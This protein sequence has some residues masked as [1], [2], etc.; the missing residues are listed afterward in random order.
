[1]QKYFL[2]YFLCF[3][4]VTSKT[5]FN[6]FQ[7]KIHGLNKEL[8]SNVCSKIKNFINKKDIT[9]FNFKKEIN[10]AIILGLRPLG[11]YEPSIDFFFKNIKK[12]NSNL[13]II[14]INPGKPILVKNI[15]IKLI[16]SL[17][18]DKDYQKILKF[19][20]SKIGK[21]LNHFDYE[22]LKEK[23][24]SLFM[25]KGYFD[26]QIK[27]NELRVSLKN[28][29]SYWIL[30]FDS[31]KR[32]HF[33]KVKYVG[34]QILKKYLNSIKTFKQKEYFSFKK[35]SEFNKRLIDTGWFNSVI[36]TPDINRSHQFNTNILPI[37]VF[38]SPKLQNHIEFGG[39][40]SKDIGFR[41][42]SI[43]NIP[44]V[45]SFGQSFFSMINFSN[46]KKT[47]DFIYKFPLLKSPLEQYYL[48]SFFYKNIK[49]EKKIFN[50]KILNISR[51]WNYY[52]GWQYKIG[53]KLNINFSIKKKNNIIFY[54]YI[55]FN[56]VEKEEKTIPS[57]GERHKYSINFSKKNIFSNINFITFQSKNTWIRTPIKYHRF[58]LK[59]YFN[60]IKTD[61]FKKIPLDIYFFFTDHNNVRKFSNK[62]I[63]QFNEKQKKS[64]FNLNF[65]SLE[66]QYNIINKW[67][68]SSFIDFESVNNHLN[69]TKIKVKSGVG[70]RWDWFFKPIKIDVIFP[71]KNFNFR[72]IKFYIG[73]G[74]EL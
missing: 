43:W 66:Y 11:Y 64:F 29:S 73:M 48:L 25:K 9:D 2:I 74:S 51:N 35:L 67:W 26:Y 46:Q 8:K 17:N 60:F 57:F 42:K 18:F 41:I 45:N 22:N 3:S 37:N 54:P 56:K 50:E 36:V 14:K 40:Y 21:I 58:L 19:S 70:L 1:M 20:K 52:H 10:N 72:K 62:N 63:L 24:H 15:K 33:G 7:I 16:G 55:V 47:V 71:M 39:A 34:S 32:Y 28:R 38:L 31:G 6:D 65:T 49:I 61:N 5:I 30:E 4:T 59:N 13:L 69:E 53:S 12:I 27:K 44:W 68:I 23:F